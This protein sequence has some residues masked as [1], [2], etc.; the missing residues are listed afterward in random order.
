MKRQKEVKK[1]RIN[2]RTKGHAFER[3]IAEEFRQLG[4]T[5][6]QTSRLVSKHRDDQKVDLVGTGIW[7]L[8]LKAVEAKLDYHE[9]LKS[10][11]IEEGQINVVFHKKNRQ[12]VTVTMSR[13]DFYSLVKMLL[14]NE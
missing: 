12:G 4:Y 14:E 6:C 13:E 7:N 1:K 10:M 8:Q 9:I 11:P 2:G 3:T 5:N